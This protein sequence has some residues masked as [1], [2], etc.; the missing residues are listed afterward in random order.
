MDIELRD[1]LAG[2][3]ASGMAS[4][5]SYGAVDDLKLDF[6]AKTAYKLADRMITEKLELDSL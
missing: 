5:L 1:Y 2:Q 4:R 3:I 6:I